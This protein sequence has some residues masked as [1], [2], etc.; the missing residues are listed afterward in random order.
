ML[1]EFELYHGAALC[2]IIH[3]ERV[4]S[5]KLYPTPNNS[6]YVLNDSIGIYLKYSGKR[7]SPWNF[8]FKKEHQDEIRDMNDKFKDVYL[9]LICGKDGIACLNYEE[10]KIVLD[11]NHE[12]S[13]WLRIMRRR[14][15]KYSVEGSD[16]KLTFKI[17]ESKF[18]DKIFKVSKGSRF[19]SF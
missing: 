16:G 7:M 15:E 8:T 4:K 19:H 14:N 1:R 5:L 10:L 2:R 18:L 9:I 6:S 13:E 17:A 11:D 12:E 3:D